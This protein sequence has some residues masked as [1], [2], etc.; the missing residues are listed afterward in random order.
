M[1]DKPYA[2]VSMEPRASQLP[3]SLKVDEME[4]ESSSESSS[5]EFVNRAR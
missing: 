5:E 2:R 3:F 4:K 1:N